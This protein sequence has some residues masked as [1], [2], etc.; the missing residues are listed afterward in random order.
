M[1]LKMW[2]IKMSVFNNYPCI[3]NMSTFQPNFNI[4]KSYWFQYSRFKYVFNIPIETQWNLIFEW[5]LPPNNISLF[6]LEANCFDRVFVSGQIAIISKYIYK[7]YVH[8]ASLK[9]ERIFRGVLITM[10]KFI[11]VFIPECGTVY[12]K[13]AQK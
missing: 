13:Q 1:V 2:V 9:D 11:L 3:K 10:Y 6:N 12:V 4:F 7:W 5:L 8:W